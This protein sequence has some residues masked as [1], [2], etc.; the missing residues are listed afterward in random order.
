MFTTQSTTTQL[1][2]VAAPLHARGT[3]RAPAVL[4]D[5]DRRAGAPASALP[6]AAAWNALPAGFVPRCRGTVSHH[7]P[8]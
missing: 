7:P 3:L 1:F 2:A 8:R 5:R 6:I 4:V